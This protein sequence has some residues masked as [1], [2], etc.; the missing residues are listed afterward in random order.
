MRVV[1]VKDSTIWVGDLRP[2]E[3]AELL[4]DFWYEK[5]HKVVQRCGRDLI[6]LGSTEAIPN[7]WT[8]ATG[9][10]CGWEKDMRVYRLPAGTILEV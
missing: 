6:V 4:G 2:G 9:G 1:E 10:S 5:E 3:I 7:V 8:T